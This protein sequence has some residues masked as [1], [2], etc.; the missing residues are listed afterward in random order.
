M[1]LG[2]DPVLRAQLVDAVSQLQKANGRVQKKYKRRKKALIC[3][4]GGGLVVAVVP[5]LRNG[6]AGKVRRLHSRGW[7]SSL[8]DAGSR[9]VSVEQ[10]VEV[11]APA[12][13][14]YNR[15]MQFEQFPTFMEGVDEVKQLDDTLLHWAVTVAG[16]KSEWDAR[17]TANDPDRRIAWESVDG[18]QTRGSVTFEPV[19]SGAR[20]KIRLQMSYTAQGTLEAAGAAAGVDEHRIRGDLARF[21]EIVENQPA[22][23]GLPQ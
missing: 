6:L 16:K 4:A 15:W 17:I 7:Q 21:R 23:P 18:T 1:R 12:S 11:N 10:Q 3:V 8:A 14:V 2:T 13:A 9:P 19:G 20:T 5:A 22:E